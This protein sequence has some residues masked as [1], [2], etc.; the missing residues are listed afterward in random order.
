MNLKDLQTLYALHPQIAAIEQWEKS[1][2]SNLKISGLSGSSFA[3]VL[4]S[5]FQKNSRTHIVVLNEEDEAAYAYNDT[6][7]ILGID[8]CFFFPSSYKKAAR[9]A[10]FSD[11]NEILRT[12]LLNRIVNRAE[13]C[14]VFT[15]PEAITQKVVSAAGFQTNILKLKKGESLGLDFLSE[16][17]VE[18][19]FSCV[20]FVY[21]PGQFSIRGGIVD[22]FSYAYEYPYRFDFFG[23]E[24]ESIRVF[25]IE[26]QLSKEHRDEVEIVPNLENNKQIRYESF[27]EFISDQSILSFTNIKYVKERLNLL[28]DDLIEKAGGEKKQL[29][30]IR[31]KYINGENLIDQI[32][33]FRKLEWSEK[34]FYNT[35]NSVKF[36]ISPQAIFH[37]NF[38]L[39]EDDLKKHLSEA[40]KIYILSDSEKQT[41]RIA[42]IF[43]DRNGQIQFQAVKN[44]LHEGFVDHDLSMVCYTDHQIFD[45]FHKYQLRT[46]KARQGKVL[47]TLK[48]INQLQIGDYIVHIDHGIGIFGG[49]V[50]MNVNGNKQEVIKLQ[51]KDNDVIFVSIHA[52]HRISKYKGKEGEAPRVNK[53]GSGAWE[54]LKERTKSKV[55]DIARELIKLYAQRKS[56]KGYAFMPDSYLQHELEASFIYED[57]PD[58][59]KATAD[60]KKDMESDVP[61]D[62]L[63]CGDVGFGKTEVAVRAAA[64]AVADSKQVAVLVPTTI[65]ALQHYNTFKDRLK[66]FPCTVEYLSRARNAKQTKEVLE[67]LAKGEIDIIIG[68]HKLVGNLVK[69]KDLGLLIIDEEQKFGVSV[70]E[71]L[72]QVKIN[73]D[74]LTMTATP[75]PRTLQF[76][77]MGARDLSIINTPPPNRYPVQTELHTFDEQLIKEAI[78]TEINRNG[79]VFFVNNRIHNIH[80][81]ESMIKN[82]IPTCRV[83]VGHGQMPSDKLEEIILDFI[84]YEYDVLIATTIIE[85]GV[86]IP[87]VN[88]IIINSAHNFGLSDLHQLRGRVGR[89][90][91]KAYCYLIAPELSLLTAD[92]R[93]R[94]QALETFSDLGSGFNIAMQ[95]LD[96]RGAG[97]M[98]GA[99][100][101]GFIADL[102]YETYQKILNEAVQELKNEEFAEL[103][104]KDQ[105][106]ELIASSDYVS[107]CQI[108]SDMELMFPADYIENVSERI[109]LYQELDSIENEEKLQVF[110]QGLEDRFGKIPQ[111]TEELFNVIRLRWLAMKYGVERLVLK[112][113]QMI[114][115]LVSNQNSFYYQSENFGK[116]LQYA[117]AHHRKCRFREQNA[118][119]SIVFSDIVSVFE[120]LSVFNEMENQQKNQ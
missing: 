45:R 18:Y 71:K 56:E 84:N 93:R 19:G 20:D 67:R 82:L 28:Y 57:T 76:S 14:V 110:A 31:S 90:N 95:D 16:A 11:S 2:E 58:Q 88:T 8:D 38:D 55:K 62:R 29:E 1:L 113:K 21:E 112:N 32:M 50:Q 17:L 61:M 80:S 10:Q 9:L 109:T 6:K 114:V 26:S 39:I 64:K 53:L 74:T 118:K 102:G 77:L 106:K 108:E 33:P 89:S 78:Q 4:S 66:K 3:L 34:S 5:L 101:S 81:I 60:V 103:Y 87:N 43:E 92:A 100:Q 117:T 119:R 13:A 85:S 70:K 94:L 69:F 73:V 37:K 105:Q 63:V 104:D 79:Q 25:D 115:F 30:Y 51:Y 7:K 99:E 72:K 98:L 65:L 111:K 97:N 59:V 75:I 40:Y 91:R 41:D 12:E 15:Y 49:L 27:F 23:D 47:L 24:I 86:D 22:I 54:R 48:D 36:N 68:T 35:Q 83:A 52:L 107:D 96:I 116:I 46:D 44:T 42:A 120:A